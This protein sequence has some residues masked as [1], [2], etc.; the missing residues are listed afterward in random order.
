VTLNFGVGFGI[1]PLSN[2]RFSSASFDS[3]ERN[4][5]L[6]LGSVQRAGLRPLP[7]IHVPLSD[8]WA[9]DAHAV[10][11]YQPALAGWVETYTAAVSYEH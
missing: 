5:V 1:N 10:V 2:G 6:A 11:A 4:V 7:L 8:A 3:P 9:L